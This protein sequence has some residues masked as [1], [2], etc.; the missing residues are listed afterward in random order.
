M[1][2]RLIQIAIAVMFVAVSL[3]STSAFGQAVYGSILGTITDPQ[4]AAVSCAKITVTDQRK[5]TSDQTTTNESS[6]YSMTHLIPDI[7]TIEVEAPGFKKLSMRDINVSADA[8]A[9]VDGQF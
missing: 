9:R 5:G 4:G 8:G 3:T 2:R 6:N 7:Y 1:I